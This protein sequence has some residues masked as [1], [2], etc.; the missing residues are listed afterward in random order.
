MLITS[1][2]LVVNNQGKMGK[3]NHCSSLT[4]K[5]LTR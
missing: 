5:K 2:Q 4:F 1:L 3:T